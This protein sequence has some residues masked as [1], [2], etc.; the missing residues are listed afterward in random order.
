MGAAARP[1]HPRALQ[2]FDTRTPSE[3]PSFSTV[4]PVLSRPIDWDLIGQQYDEMV[5]YAT[6]LRVGTSDAE[7][8]LRRF[9][10]T[11]VQHPTY[12]ALAELGKAERTTFLCRY[13]RR[14]DLRREIHEGL[15]VSENWYSANAFIHYGRAGEMATNNREDQE[16]GM[17]CLHLLQA[18]LVY[19]NTLMVQQVL[20][21]SSMGFQQYPA[22][23]AGIGRT[24]PPPA[25]TAR[26]RPSC[27]KH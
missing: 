10:R 12:R 20:S 7:S 4:Q 19:I 26:P 13:L 17:L 14:K 2:R 27:R 23:P 22:D 3:K 8:I 9:T 11:N 5:K 21:F 1:Q 24:T 6:A 25:Q 15:N 18:C 16:T